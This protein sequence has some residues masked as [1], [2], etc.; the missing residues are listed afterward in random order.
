MDATSAG[1][2]SPGREKEMPR[3]VV[4]TYNT[5]S[6]NNTVAACLKLMCVYKYT[7]I[8]IIE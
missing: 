5:C 6:K 3:H 2:S 1:V 4:P 8:I 7:I